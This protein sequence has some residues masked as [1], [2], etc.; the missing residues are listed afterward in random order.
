G[1]PQRT[2]RCPRGS[3]GGDP[4]G[5]AGSR[6]HLHDDPV[7]GTAVRTRDVGSFRQLPDT[8]VET[9]GAVRCDACRTGRGNRSGPRLNRSRTQGVA[10]GSGPQRTTLTSLPGTTMT[11]L[12]S[13]PSR[14]STIFSS[15]S[16]AAR[17]ASSSASAATVTRERTL[18]LTWIGYSAVSATR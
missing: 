5:N 4:T 6:N 3:R 11:F 10:P 16:A 2:P 17:T 8:D 7:L 9:R 18:P 12:G 13:P 14:V 15:A 1:L